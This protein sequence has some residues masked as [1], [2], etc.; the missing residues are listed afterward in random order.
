MKKTAILILLSALLGLFITASEN[1]KI[2]GTLFDKTENIQTSKTQKTVSNTDFA[3]K[4]K[5]LLSN[6]L[7]AS[8]ISPDNFNKVIH[9]ID[10]F[11]AKET[12]TSH[13]CILESLKASV[14]AEYFQNIRNPYD[15]RQ[16]TVEEDIE[17]VNEWDKEKF[18]SEIYTHLDNSLA[19]SEIT[20][21]IPTA[22]FAKV[23]AYSET[24]LELCPTL[25][26]FLA[27]RAMA[28]YTQFDD[29]QKKQEVVESVA[30]MHKGDMP[31]EIYTAMLDKYSL[32][33]DEAVKMYN[34]YKSNQYSG[35]ILSKIELYN[36]NNEEKL[37]LYRITS[38][39]LEKYRD[40]PFAG[41]IESIYNHTTEKSIRINNSK[42]F[43]D[44]D[45]IK[46]KAEVQN[47]DSY[48]VS[49][50]RINGYHIAP[51]YR[52]SLIAEKEIV[53]NNEFPYY[54]RTDIVTFDPMP[55][56]NYAVKVEFM[57]NGKTNNSE[58]RNTDF[59]VS[60]IETVAI[61][62]N[63]S[64][65]SRIIA[66]NGTTGK[67]MKNVRIDILKRNSERLFH[68]SFTNS[69]GYTDVK[70]TDYY[71]TSYKATKGGDKY[72]DS[73]YFYNHNANKQIERNCISTTFTDLAVYHPGETVKFAAIATS[74]FKKDVKPLA[75]KKF[76]VTFSDASYSEIAKSEIESDDF[77]RIYGSFEIPKGRMNGSFLIK[78]LNEDLD[79]SAYKSVNVAE[80]KVPQFYVEFSDLQ[81]RYDK[82]I[83]SIPVKGKAV[84]YSNVP[85]TN[86]KVK[87]TLDYTQWN[88]WWRRNSEGNTLATYDAVTDANG[89]FVVNIPIKQ[90]AKEIEGVDFFV[91]YNLSADVTSGSGE[92]QSVKDYFIL[93]DFSQP[94]F[95]QDVNINAEIPVIL[96]V[97]IE[98][99]LESK[100]TCKFKLL[101]KSS[102]TILSGEF[103]PEETAIDLSKVES[104]T[105]TLSVS[106]KGKEEDA[107]E[108]IVYIYR[109][110]DKKC[111]AKSALWIADNKINQ[112][113]SGK[114]EILLG[115]D[116]ET[117]IYY[118]VQTETEEIS[119]GWKHFDAGMNKLSV[120]LP[121]SEKKSHMQVNLFT[122]KNY[123]LNHE[124]INIIPYV[125]PE[126]LNVTIES[127]RN[128]VTAG[129]NETWKLKYRSNEGKPLESAVIVNIYDK[130]LDAIAENIFKYFPAN[131][132]RLSCF[133]DY[134]QYGF[135][136]ESATG[137]QSVKHKLKQ[138][139]I[140]H[141]NPDT[142]SYFNQRRMHSYGEKMLCQS[143]PS[144]NCS[145]DFAE[146]EVV[147]DET[148]EPM[149]ME[150][151]GTD[152]GAEFKTE[153]LDNVEIREGKLN[154]ALWLPSLKSDKD[155]NLTVE[156][157]VPNYNTT[158]AFKTIAYTK[159]FLANNTSREMVASKPVM[160]QPNL[161]RFVRQGDAATVSALVINSSD[162]AQNVVAQVELYN[163]LT[164]ENI[165]T[166]HF[167]LSLEKGEQKPVV[168]SW[169]VPS[170]LSVIGYRI[171]AANSNFS[172]GEQN[173][174]PVLSSVSPVVE[175]Y[176]FYLNPNQ[177][178]LAMQLPN[179][180]KGAKVTVEY[181]D[182]P[183]WLCLTALPSILDESDITATSIAHK[184][185]AIFVAEG[186]VS[187][188]ESIR[189][190]V[191]YW[192]N[193][194]QDSMLVS[195][196][197]KNKDLKIS[198]LANSPWLTA[199]Q[200][201]TVTM[202]NIS[203]LA[204]KEYT[205]KILQNS[206]D[207]LK[208]IQ[209]ID[210]G[211]VWYK[212]CHKSSYYITAAVLNL[213]G[214][215][216]MLG[217]LPNDADLTAIIRKAIKYYDVEV[218]NIY[219]RQPNKNDLSIFFD[220]AYVRSM[221]KD[222]PR[223]NYLD[224]MV[225]RA[226]AK[227]MKNWKGISIM[228]KTYLALVLAQENRTKEAKP[229]IDYI[230]EYAIVSPDKGIR[231]DYV[232][233]LYS[234]Q[235]VSAV[236][237]I[238]T[239]IKA[240]YPE[241]PM[242]DGIR[243]WI[244]I[245]KKANYWGDSSL[246][247]Q[248]VFSIL[249]TGSNWLEESRDA[250]IQIGGKTIVPD[251][252][253]KMTGYM[254]NE[255]K[256]DAAD[257]EL[258]VSRTGNTPAFGSVY[259]QYPAPMTEIEAVGTDDITIT[260]RLYDIDGNMLK[261]TD[262]FKVGDKVR[263]MLIVKSKQD[264]S[265]VTLKDERCASM[266][267]VD[268]LSKYT[269]TDGLWYYQETKESITNFFINYLPKGTYRL[270]YDVTITSPGKYNLGI[271]TIQSQY[272]P[273]YTAHSAGEKVDVNRE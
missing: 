107:I 35:L 251:K 211:F 125:K 269:S 135:N 237:Q 49:V 178:E 222:I 55:F 241:D 127:F 64:D 93:G 177:K 57:D 88:F 106:L 51:K 77:G 272:A 10:S 138:L 118:I 176:P 43:S 21:T 36:L 200:H 158:W 85:L 67:P 38:D 190:A 145:M 249:N 83:T 74:T 227:R 207:A 48:K 210:G 266:E 267:P 69:E 246:A 68:S 75:H 29:T 73:N 185:Y 230:K 148:I 271:A 52:F 90:I 144:H 194:P 205:D 197:E 203:K 47:I 171:K 228:D 7:K 123:E 173:V 263:V 80:Y 245:N 102:K 247:A 195:M 180:P 223:S 46:I 30:G 232:G 95:T 136:Y 115:S 226:I 109:P 42:I 191:K 86:C 157:T 208:S 209:K 96:P 258:T 184:L 31:I 218:I 150:S 132:Y 11:S 25:Y 143:M 159:D 37:Q 151:N 152:A 257:T 103:V 3:L 100:P 18:K 111:P 213:L 244:L 131:N 181:Y 175:S 262:A 27:Y 39:F 166:E 202:K 134:L 26:D 141:F 108:K 63:E 250:K 254:Q 219:N 242:I 50:Y 76:T 110:T 179:A 79:V 14:Y 273:E 164:G 153:I 54:N 216:K 13:I 19:H 265:Y 183:S 149:E 24:G 119:S 182:N 260:K 204:D 45:S 201:E 128:K 192:E 130:A 147:L 2:S 155:G 256:I 225:N 268:Q 65:I 221:H 124:T 32:P 87:L 121:L 94:L 78:F 264:M 9:K 92:T 156:F 187:G 22:T 253:E 169:N 116:T 162:T 186:I 8:Q 248:C 252:F 58:L 199:A 243:Q 270:Y 91:Q 70:N 82:N 206:I 163:P 234:S 81:N 17:D 142:E 66:T 238:L 56:G 231:W 196:L 101:D 40:Y 20:S 84:S 60:N 114:A 161:P 71:A 168:I 16:K 212:E 235:K 214:E 104:G 198:E 15:D 117:W 137:R 129:D 34:T 261:R 59:T 255:I 170:E 44:K 215:V 120:T 133:Y 240:V 229:I 174:I 154:N 236:A 139:I 98:T 105:Y 217:Y 126:K 172:D 5:K 113:E 61:G 189:D 112:E 239:A 224:K 193:N 23:L 99:S 33:F 122:I 259:V 6:T 167:N 72:G 53:V 12:E 220:Y 160:V 146:A 140:P 41:A 28:I 188:N 97:K 233:G 62:N 89:E 165:L 1:P 4:F